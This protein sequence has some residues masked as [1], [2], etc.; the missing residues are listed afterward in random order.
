[1]DNRRL[2]LYKEDFSIFFFFLKVAFMHTK[3]MLF[4]GR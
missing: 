4:H 3:I 1:M 2:F